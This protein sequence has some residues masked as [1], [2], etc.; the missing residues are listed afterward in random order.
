MNNLE[1]SDRKTL[2]ENIEAQV[3]QDA[4]FITLYHPMKVYVRSDDVSGLIVS[5]S[6]WYMGLGIIQMETLQLRRTL[7]DSG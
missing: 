5:S 1:R 4:P 3:H 2:Y 6:N 7:R